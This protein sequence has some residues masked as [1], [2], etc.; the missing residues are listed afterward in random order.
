M[1]SILEATYFRLPLLVRQA[2]SHFVSTIVLTALVLHALVSRAMTNMT[3]FGTSDRNQKGFKSTTKSTMN[4]DDIVI[5]ADDVTHEEDDYLLEDEPYHDSF[6]VHDYVKRQNYDVED[7]IVWTSDGHQLLLHRISSP[8]VT[9]Y[10]KHPVLLMHGL[11]QSSGVYVSTGRRSLAYLLI[12]LGYDVWLG[13]SR[14]LPIDKTTTYLSNDKLHD[15]KG[16]QDSKKKKNWNFDIHDL[17][18]YDLPAI[19]D[20]VCL[21]TGSDSLHYIGHSQG[22]AQAFIGFNNPDLR[23]KIKSF[24]ALA[25][26]AYLGTFGW[27][28]RLLVELEEHWFEF[29]F[30]TQE[31]IPIMTLVHH[32]IPI[33]L[34]SRMGYL[35][36]S[37]LFNWSDCLWDKKFK[38]ACFRFTPRPTS[39]HVIKHWMRSARKGCLV[40]KNDQ[41]ISLE[42]LKEMN[43]FMVW[44]TRDFLVDAKTLL[45]K[46]NLSVKQLEIEGYEHV[47]F[48]WGKCA[49]ERCWDHIAEFLEEHE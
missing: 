49:K 39:A 26:S 38:H 17:A 13:N 21:T 5:V 4:S 24:T 27:P 29:I 19:I 45:K 46:H 7:S 9:A 30:G 31:F 6:A 8:N 2:I 20:H 43:V 37:F 28:M 12:D 36:F 16:K 48:L 33:W 1:K 22:N 14:G 18:S 34:F 3:W 35:M 47:E 23:K 10:R 42:Y 11:L 32:T 25:P 15:N 41:Q 40:D 44:G